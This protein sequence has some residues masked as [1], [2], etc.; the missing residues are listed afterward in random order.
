MRASQY[1]LFVRGEGC[2]YAANLLTRTALELSP[3]AHAAYLALERGEAP[4]AEDPEALAFL[5]ALRRG[6]F[7]IPNDFDELAYIRG[8]VQQER[9]DTRHLGVVIAPTLECN[10]D[11]HYCFESKRA[12]RMTS[13]AQEQLVRLVTE[14]LPGCRELSVQ[15]FGGEPLHALDVLETLSRR[16]LRL[17]REAGVSYVATVVTNG[18]LM[19]A[20]VST[21]L[22]DLGV[23]TAQISLDGDRAL[24]DRTRREQSGLGSFDVIL[25]NIRRASSHI[26]VK[27]RVHVAPFSVASVDQLLQTLAECGVGPHIAELYLAP[28]FNYHAGRARGRSYLPDGRRFMTAREFAAVQVELL[29]RAVRLGFRVPDF[30]GASYGICTAVRGNTVVIDADGN[31]LSCYKDVGERREAVGSLHT[32]ESSPANRLK[33]MDVPVP[34][35]AECR[36]CTFLPLCL[37]GCAKQWHEGAPKDVI[38]TPLRFNFEDRVRLALGPARQ[39]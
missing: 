5:G 7:L 31:L 29:A 39:S 32:A 36:G 37:G 15:W 14:R 10:F 27:L 35:D 26:A 6:L 19:T 12:G 23:T 8:R 9:F 38:C 13:Q 22:A 25:E 20:E 24:H 21:R 17:A 3:D 33:W 34:R 30:L 28:L 1:N 18:F 2:V 4:M 11:C 16:L